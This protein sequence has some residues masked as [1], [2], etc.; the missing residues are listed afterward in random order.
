MGCYSSKAIGQNVN[1]RKWMD[2]VPEEVLAI[3]LGMIGINCG[4]IRLVCKRWKNCMIVQQCIN[5]SRV[6][7]CDVGRIF[8]GILVIV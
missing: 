2:K 3:V 8:E 7:I 1:G 6:D 4:K 5:I